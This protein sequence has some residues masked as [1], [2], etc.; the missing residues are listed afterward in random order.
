MPIV[1]YSRDEMGGVTFRDEAGRSHYAY[2][3]EADKLAQYVDQTRP[4]VP[5][6]GPDLR[7]ASV[8]WS[9]GDTA[10]LEQQM[11]GALNPPTHNPFAKHRQVADVAPPVPGV[12]APQVPP[13]APQ[14][15]GDLDLDALIDQGRQGGA[16]PQRQPGA[17][18][19]P[20][21][22][23]PVYVPGRAAVD[24]GRMAREG[25]PVPRSV[26]ET[27][28]GGLPWDQEAADTRRALDD[29]VVE[30]RMVA[31]ARDSQQQLNAALALKAQQPELEAQAARAQQRR[32]EIRK[33]YEA[34]RQRW[35][36]LQQAATG[37]QIDPGRMFTG[38]PVGGILAV[39]ASGLGA[40]G[41]AAGG[42]Q[43]FAQQIIDQAIDRDI[44][45]QR[46]NIAQRQHR[47]DNALQRLGVLYDG[48]LD[49]AEQALRG[50]M[51]SW[52][53]AQ[54]QIVAHEMGSEQSLD[55]YQQWLADSE[56]ARQEREQKF[57][58]RSLGKHTTTVQQEVVQPQRG[59]AGGYRAP[60]TD[61]MLKRKKLYGGDEN[62]WG[63]GTR[64]KAVSEYGKRME[65][66]AQAEQ[67]LANYAEAMGLRQ[68]E[69]ASDVE[70][71]LPE[72]HDIP[73]TGWQSVVPGAEQGLEAR[74]VNRQRDLA[75]EWV[76]TGITGAAATPEQIEAFKAGLEDRTDAGTV[77]A[78]NKMRR[79]LSAAKEKVNG[80]FGPEVAAEFEANVRGVNAMHQRDS[81]IGWRPVD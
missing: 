41:A 51:H 52:A 76:T 15:S 53:D 23:A 71:V 68:K 50:A 17:A 12:A 35:S 58:E 19:D 47:A 8:D 74:D 18:L 13:Q 75:A 31:A 25:V 29:Q 4:A 11:A 27:R 65:Q 45:A 61:E 59:Y 28:E 3:D 57:M 34:D 16:S 26:T 7:T 5:P 67:G 73:A 72:G 30:A 48:D 39:I 77:G 38:N 69:G 40:L 22:T 60:D 37:E 70:W 79:A 43:N 66:I 1:D 80:A 42:G 36:E 63:E 64:A 9:A 10:A 62:R 20:R 54:K 2:G 32:D 14:P 33:R 6:P 24:P 21:V 81:R 56:V 44:A 49:M 55:A 78:L 46:A